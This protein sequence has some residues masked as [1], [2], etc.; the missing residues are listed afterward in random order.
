M[1]GNDGIVTWGT[2][3]DPNSQLG[4]LHH[5][6]AGLPVPTADL[7]NLGGTTGS[8]SLIGS[9][10][11]TNSSDMV[12]GTL[13]SANLIVQFGASAPVTATMN[14]TIN[15]SP[16]NATLASSSGQTSATFLMSGNC[17]GSC[18]V[19]ANVALFGPNAARAGMIYNIQDFTRTPTLDALGAAA[20]AKK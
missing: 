14:W 8:Y 4:A 20:F 19:N 5:F 2:F 6:V 3:T 11:V 10:P 18:A 12:I 17:G 15:G 9:T 1:G 13:N 16:L 7:V